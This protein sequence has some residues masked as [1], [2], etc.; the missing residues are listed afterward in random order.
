MSFYQSPVPFLFKAISAI[1]KFDGSEYMERVFS[2]RTFGDSKTFERIIR[3]R[4]LSILRK[5]SENDDDATDE[6]VLKQIV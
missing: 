6:D 4:L 2:L 5:Y 1:D 3:S